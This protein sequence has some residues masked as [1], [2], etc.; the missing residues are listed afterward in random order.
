LEVNL[1]ITYEVEEKEEGWEEV[2]VGEV[3]KSILIGVGNRKHT[4]LNFPGNTRSPCL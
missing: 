4:A 1:S 3:R 2:V